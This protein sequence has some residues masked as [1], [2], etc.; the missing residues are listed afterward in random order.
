MNARLNTALAHWNYVAPLLQPIRND[1]EYAEMVES[2]DSV[3][4]AGGADESHPLAGLA[5]M[6]GERISAYEAKRHPMPPALSA[7]ETLAFFMQQQH[8]RQS[9]LPE[10]GTQGV[11]SELLAG[12][13]QL[14]L[15]QAQMLAHRFGVGIETFLP[16]TPAQSA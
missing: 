11:I 12:K 6:L 5:D 15:R 16:L 8:L 2:L 4:D 14:N 10:V 9:D 13:R 3:L 1:Q 7:H